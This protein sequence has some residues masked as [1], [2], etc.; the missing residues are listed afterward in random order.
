MICDMTIAS[1]SADE[2]TG[3]HG[4]LVESLGLAICGGTLAPGTVLFIDE[5]VSE[6]AVSRSVVREALRV[7]ASMGLVA[8]RRRVGT[9]VLA[10]P[11]WNVYDPLD[12]RWRLATDGR[13]AQLRS[14]T[15]LR[16]AVE[17]QAARL[18]AER[19]MPLEAS[20]LVS[21]AGQLWAA[22]QDGRMD[23][24]LALDIEFHRRVLAASGNE[25][26]EHLHRQVAEVL[27]GRHAYGLMPHHPHVDALQLHT[28]VASSIQRGD[29]DMA[30]TAMVAIMDR[31]MGETKQF[32]SDQTH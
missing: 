28:D 31:T 10:P 19:A 18:A 25:M 15:E 11:A 23:D 24:F 14:I 29:G 5:L 16:T 4:R 7:L 13:I 21:L 26:F 17:P 9:L 20:E 30:H 8:S 12:I 3:L 1:P 32:W 6:H 27:T 2:L 22:G